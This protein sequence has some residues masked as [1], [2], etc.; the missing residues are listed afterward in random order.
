MRYSLSLSLFVVLI[1]LLVDFD[2]PW[3][4]LAAVA[5]DGAIIVVVTIAGVMRMGRSE[6]R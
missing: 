1:W 5:I 3:P 4:V 2:P 6:I